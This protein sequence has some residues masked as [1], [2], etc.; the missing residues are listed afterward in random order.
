MKAKARDE[1]NL[2]DYAVSWGLIGTLTTINNPIE[3]VRFR[4]QVMPVLLEQGHLRSPYLSCFD[5]ARTIFANEGFRSFF[6]GNLSN[7]IRVVPSETL[8]FQLKEYFQRHFHYHH[9]LS[10]AEHFKYNTFIGISAA[11]IV[12]LSLYPL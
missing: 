11:M 6:K 3:L 9:Q 10:D 2:V 5:C 7:M 4:M 1:W 8:V 12:S